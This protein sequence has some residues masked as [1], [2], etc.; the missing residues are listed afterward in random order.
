MVM[1]VMMMADTW[2][3]TNYHCYN[4]VM[5]VTCKHISNAGEGKGGLNH[6]PIKG[7]VLAKSEIVRAY[8][9]FMLFSGIVCLSLV[10]SPTIGECLLWPNIL[11]QA[12]RK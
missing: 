3:H 2:N 1:D 12:A 4:Q 7:H 10:Q 8:L 11:F 5:N 9:F 6:T